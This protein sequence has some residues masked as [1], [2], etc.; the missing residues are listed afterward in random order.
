LSIGVTLYQNDY[1]DDYPIGGWQIPD[2]TT[3]PTFSDRWYQ[4]I[5]PYTKSVTI[6]NCPGSDFKVTETTTYNWN[7]DYGINSS[8]APWEDALNASEV[9]RPASM[10]L[11]CDTAQYDYST[12]PSSADNSIPS[13]WLTHATGPTDFQVEGPY[14][15]Y[16]YTDYPYNDP[17]D[18]FGNSFRRPYA[19]H[20]GLVNVGFCDGHSHSMEI[21]ALVGPMPYGYAL[22]DPRNLWSNSN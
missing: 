13:K 14:I 21:G 1:D 12:F 18:Q 10:V 3:T 11:L 2:N 19:V 4:D 5:A 16:P 8:I 22:S 15:F 7:T 6:R 17:P 20:H 9:N